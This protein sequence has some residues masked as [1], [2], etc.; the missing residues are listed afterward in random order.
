MRGREVERLRGREKECGW[1]VATVLY[2]ACSYI[3]YD[4]REKLMTDG[5]NKVAVS[6]C[7]CNR[8]RTKAL[9]THADDQ[10]TA[11][12]CR[13]KTIGCRVDWWQSARLSALVAAGSYRN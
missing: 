10:H 12:D 8:E 9:T 2:A 4:R 13:L 11:V 5:C 6:R 1:T 7:G 3:Y